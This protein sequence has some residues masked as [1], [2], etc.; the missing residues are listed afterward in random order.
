[1]L[2]LA[3]SAWLMAYGLVWTRRRAERLL[4]RPL[5]IARG[6][7]A[8]AVALAMLVVVAAPVWLFVGVVAM[9]LLMRTHGVQRL[10]S[11]L[12]LVLAAVIPLV[13]APLMGAPA[14]FALDAA[15]IA[16]ATLGE[17]HAS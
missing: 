11:P 5:P 7:V 8:L 12:V 10:P 2:V 1:M 17:A 16:A 13:V 14:G 3:F 6:T 9:L 15:L 4:A